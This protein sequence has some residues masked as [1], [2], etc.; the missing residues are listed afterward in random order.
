MQQSDLSG[1]PWRKSS[2]SGEG[3]SCVEMAFVGDTVAVRD[4]KNRE[5]GTLIF[6]RNEWTTF[7]SGIKNSHFD[8]LT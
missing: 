7:I 6:R 8:K 3:A 5:G 1:A 2:L 4:T